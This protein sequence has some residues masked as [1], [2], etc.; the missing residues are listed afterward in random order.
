MISVSSITLSGLCPCCQTISQR[1]RV[2]SSYER[3]PAD[4]SLA[5]CSVRLDIAVRR[6]F[7]D[8]DECERTIFAERMPSLTAP[9]ARR[10]GRLAY[11]QQ[12]VAFALGGEA[13]AVLL[14][15]MGK[16]P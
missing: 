16:A 9:Y 10:T 5:G 14:T 13:G 8:N 2:H 1:Q 15:V 6:F 4:V 7:C 11:Q 3:H 12:K